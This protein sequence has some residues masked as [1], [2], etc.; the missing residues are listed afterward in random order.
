MQTASKLW[1]V[2]AELSR[3][4]WG[5]G[6][7]SRSGGLG[8]FMEVGNQ[9][10]HLARFWC[11]VIRHSWAESLDMAWERVDSANGQSALVS[12]ISL[13][14]KHTWAHPSG[15]LRK[16]EIVRVGEPGGRSL[17]ADL[18]R[19]RHSGGH[20]WVW[21]APTSRELTVLFDHVC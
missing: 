9:E 3:L 5:T 2:Q 4:R 20:V 7:R 21:P 1:K 6:C 14:R 15:I 12:R 13:S 8:M 10:T 17:Q 19:T 18:S 11:T 16:G